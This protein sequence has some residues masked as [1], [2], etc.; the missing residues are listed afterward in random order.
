MLTRLLYI[1]AISPQTSPTDIAAIV[2]T[3]QLRNRRR[4]LTG[5]LIASRT[6]FAQVLE[7]RG[8]AIDELLRRVVQDPRH[9]GVRIQ[10]REAVKLRRFDRWSMEFVRRDDLGEQLAAAHRA[11]PAPGTVEALMQELVES[12]YERG[13]RL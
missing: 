11:A 4:D 7:G 1:S 13:L 5:L 12:S 3:A 6:H 2:S 8:E 9:I 10:S